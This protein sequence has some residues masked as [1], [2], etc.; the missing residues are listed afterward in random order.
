MTF[1]LG[2]FSYYPIA[3]GV[4]ILLLLIGLAISSYFVSQ[5][6][7]HKKTRRVSVLIANTVAALAVVGLAFDIQITNKQVSVTYL[8]TNGATIEQLSQIDKQQPIFIMQGAMGVMEAMESISDNN[9]VDIATAI[10]IPSQVLSHQPDISNLHVLGDGLSAEQWRDMQLLIGDTFKNISITFSTFKPRIGLINMQWPREL[11]VGQFIQIKGQLQGSDGPDTVD[12]IYQVTLVDPIGQIVETIRLKASESFTLSFPATSIGQWVYRLQLSKSGENNPIADEPIA[13]VVAKPATLRILIKQSAPSFE[14]R[15]L[16]NWAAEFGSQISVLTQISQTKDIRQNINMDT[17]TLE[18]ITLTANEPFTEQALVNFDWLLIDGRALLTLT[19][20]QTTAL[21]TAIKNGLGM[22]II[23][24]NEL[25]NAW[26]VPSLDWLL[27]INLQPLDVANYSAIPYWPH[28]KIE[29]AMPLVKANITSARGAYLVQNKEAQILVSHSK[30]GLGHVAV[31]LIN[32]TYGWQTSGLTEQYSHYWQ[33]V[34][35]ELARPKQSAYWQSTQ[36]NSLTLVNKHMQKC[37]L[38]A[39]ELGVTTYDQ[40][41]YPLILTQDLIQT[42]QQCLTMWPTNAGWHKLIWSE[43]TTVTDTN[44]ASTSSVNTWFYAHAEQDWQQW[45]Q[46][47]NQ[48][49]SQKIAQ[50][51]I[52]KKGE[53]PSVKSLD[54]DWVWALLVLSMS[55]LWLERKLFKP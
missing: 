40:H 22:Y 15:Q 53:K 50:Q 23:T 18:Q 31:S 3:A 1:S 25:I 26:P 6:L 21:Q 45:R 32:T 10:H 39:T 7:K 52:T 4:L 51:Q 20:Q 42:E 49:V 43:N 38:G 54:K 48:L 44:N 30:I 5:R 9:I 11:A 33:S 29:Q 13:F 14:T 19:A 36:P 34:I 27:D 35:Y 47:K 2:L 55:L 17:E 12:N 28:S 16:K 8:V 24:D 46:V 41:P 37:L